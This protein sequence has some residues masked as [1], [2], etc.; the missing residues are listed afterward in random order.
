MTVR[1]T[2]L[3]PVRLWVGD[4]EVDPGAPKQV[5]LL[6]MLL[7]AG[8]RPVGLAELVAA[9]WGSEPPASAVNIV[10]RFVGALR[11]LIEP[12]LPARATGRWLLASAGG[13]RIDAGPDS[14]D[15]LRFR[16]L[17]RQARYAEALDL[18]Q[19]PAGAGL[20][21]SVR[22]EPS[23]AALNLE[24]ATV[25]KAAADAALTTGTDA[26]RL[27]PGVGRAADL[28]PFDEPLQ[29][30]FIRLLRA[31]GRPGDAQARFWTVADRLAGEFGLDPG[32]ELTAALGDA[33]TPAQLPADLPAFAGRAAELA[34]AMSLLDTGQAPP[35]VLITAIGGM[36]GVG[37]TALAVHWAHRVADRF[38]DGQLYVN[39]RGFDPQSAPVEPA[40]AL[41]GLLRTLDAGPGD[42]G[43]GLAELSARFRT[44]TAGRRM[45]LVLDNARD[46]K[47]VRPLLPASPS[48]LVIVTS[49]NLLGGLV[50]ADGAIPLPLDRLGDRESRD[51][52]IRRLGADRAGAEPDAVA[53]IVARCAGLPLALSIVAARAAL[54]PS[55]PLDALAEEL[56]AAHGSL[57]AFAGAETAVDARAVFSWSYRA[58][59][60]AAARLFRLLGVH[61]GPDLSAPAAASVAGLPADRVRPLLRELVRAQLLTE[62]APGRFGFHD[63]LRAYAIELADD[64]A[65][66]ARERMLDHYLHSA[67]PANRLLNPGAHP[68]PVAEPAGGVTPERVDDEKQAF[69]WYRAEE[70]V[71]FETVP[72]AVRHGL[73]RHAVLLGRVTY[74]YLRRQMAPDRVIAM[75]TIASAAVDRLGDDVLR[76]AV[77]LNLAGL[78]VQA[79][80]LDLADDEYRRALAGFERM[81]D[82]VGQTAVHQGLAS[83][84]DRRG[85][86]HET[87][88]HAERA[89]AIS[90]RIGDRGAELRALGGLAWART[91]LGDYR[92][93]LALARDLADLSAGAD[94]ADAGAMWHTIG[95]AHLRLGEHDRAIEILGRA[96]ELLELAGERLLSGLTLG[97]LGEA[98]AAAGDPAT[99]R[100]RRRPSCPDGRCRTCR[101]APVYMRRTPAAA[102]NSGPAPAPTRRSSTCRRTGRCGCATD[103]CRSPTTA[104]PCSWPPAPGRP[105]SNSPSMPRTTWSMCRSTGVWRCRAGTVATASRPG[106]RPAPAPAARNGVTEAGCPG[107]RARSGRR[108]RPPGTGRA[109][110]A[111]S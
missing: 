76:G 67:L 79:G 17:G 58:L 90:R 22:T 56:R 9:L 87:I 34:R 42:Q 96:A 16:D 50:A 91:Q 4:A 95:Y 38:P 52:L 109:R 73:D 60:P 41:R 108:R 110:P 68:I 51:L 65:P 30:R 99:A 80:R 66:A 57:E 93:A 92:D 11:R 78:Y 72:L 59:T 6:A 36:A 46:E 13:Y 94:T 104:P 33:A 45:L 77:S 18:W 106:S 25:A 70:A 24:H 28:A 88:R 85:A 64:E 86:H 105:A 2:V 39:L 48:C 5:A 63:L 47:Q 74:S 32:P 7:V 82:L 20:P 15:L 44:R 111:A 31:A 107:S 40:E 101:P 14:L 83:S 55:F 43:A 69:T 26:A 62:S 84:S 53:E 29:A 54:H 100:P 27:L 49:R 89:L 98:C 21:A 81:A 102:S 97:H 19:G 71:L 37:K 3:G 75:M 23:V 10:H 35:A 103:V 61:P 1:F 8:G 12:E